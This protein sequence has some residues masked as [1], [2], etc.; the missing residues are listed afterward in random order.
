M[1]FHLDYFNYQPGE[2]KNSFYARKLLGYID[3]INA[4]ILHALHQ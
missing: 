3:K 1:E 2:C 4:I